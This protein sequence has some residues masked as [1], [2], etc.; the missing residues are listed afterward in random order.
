MGHNHNTINGANTQI[1]QLTKVTGLQLGNG[2]SSITGRSPS[3]THRRAAAAGRRKA[4]RSGHKIVTVGHHV[5]LH[6]WSP[7]QSPVRRY[8]KA[9]NNR[10]VNGHHHQQYVIHRRTLPQ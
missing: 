5:T 6:V 8:N 9:T 7:R 1:N 3:S 2:V 10:M 4:G